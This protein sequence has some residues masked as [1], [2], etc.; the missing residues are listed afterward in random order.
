MAEIS[1]SLTHSDIKI[2]EIYVNTP[3][4]VKLSTYEKYESRLKEEQLKD[5]Y[6]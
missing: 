1:E 6:N 5:K 3:N 2:I 4:V